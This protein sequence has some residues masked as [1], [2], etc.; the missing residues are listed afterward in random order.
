M[1]VNW[2]CWDLRF[3]MT[4]K[5]KFMRMVCAIPGDSVLTLLPAGCGQEMWARIHGRRLTLLKKGKITAGELWK[6]ITAII[7]LPTAILR[8]LPYPYGN[9]NMTIWGVA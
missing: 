5:K 6:G 8:D 4:I 3:I 9:M 2:V 7:R 1:A